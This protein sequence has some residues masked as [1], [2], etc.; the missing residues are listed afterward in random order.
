MADL[1]FT[2]KVF[3]T[4]AVIKRQCPP[5]APYAQSAGKGCCKHNING[6]TRW[7]MKKSDRAPHAQNGYA[8]CGQGDTL[9]A[10]PACPE[11]YANQTE[12]FDNGNYL[13]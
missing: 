13:L 5:D 2:D 1:F 3:Y 12:C 6:T 8:F 7:G 4:L 9:I 10:C 11:C